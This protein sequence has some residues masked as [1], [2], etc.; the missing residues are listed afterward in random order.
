MTSPRERLKA[1]QEQRG[2][3]ARQTW[4]ATD[5]LRRGL[6][7]GVAMVIGGA[8]LHRLAPILL[9]APLLI[10]SVL[11]ILTPLRGRPRIRVRPLPRTVESG[12]RARLLVDVEPGDGAELV[13][14]RLPSP[15]KSGIGPVHVV[16]ATARTLVTRMHWDAWG[17]HFDLRPDHLVAG[18]DGLWAYGPVVGDEARRAVLPLVR[19]LPPG[20]RRHRAA[21]HPRLPAR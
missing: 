8:L 12:Q 7:L 15:D 3:Q 13:A 6:V 1:W 2:A 5:A 11:A 21:Q 18:P 20:R 17:E 9:G 19:P 16:P 14:I 4:R 10:G